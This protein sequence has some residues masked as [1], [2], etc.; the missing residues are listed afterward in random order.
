MIFRDAT[1]A[2]LPAIVA[3]LDDDE[4]SRGRE[5][6]SLPLDPRYEMAFADLDSDP[7]QRLIVAERDGAV[8][9][10]MQ[11]SFLPGI[12]FRGAW[13]GQIEAVRIAAS[14]RGQGLGQ[15]MIEWA[16]A[17]CRARGCRMVQLTSMRDRVDAHRFY[18]KLGWTR[19]HFGF[20]L[21][22]DEDQG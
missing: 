5:D 9:G 3:M 10:T 11:L 4:L 21:K 12:A 17:Q 13:R 7:N 15:Q 20:K 8:I 6:A 2:D 16:V 1:L 18:E 22:L 14:E 19:S